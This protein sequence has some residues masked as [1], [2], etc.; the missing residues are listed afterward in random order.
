MTRALVALPQLAQR[1]VTV[2]DSLKRKKDQPP[3][4]TQGPHYPAHW[5]QSIS[6]GCACSFREEKTRS[7]APSDTLE[8]RCPAP[9]A[10]T[11]AGLMLYS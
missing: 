11:A 4:G 10:I 3:Q 6:K 8:V 7:P 5:L 2:S 9:G 1:H